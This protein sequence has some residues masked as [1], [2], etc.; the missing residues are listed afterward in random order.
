MNFLTALLAT[1]KVAAGIAIAVLA[2]GAAVG[3]FASQDKLPGQP[4]NILSFTSSESATPGSR[5]EATD[6]PAATSTPRAVVGIPT[7]NPAHDMAETPGACDHGDTAV[8]TTPSGVPVNVPCEAIHGTK[9]PEAD[10]TPGPD[11][12][13]TETA[14][15]TEA[16]EATHQP[17]ATE[18]PDAHA[19]PE[20]HGTPGA[21]GEKDAHKG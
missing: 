19:T 4:H 12:R 21:H 9:T 7:T 13:K 16:A 18:Q 14:K 8:K 20:A 17:E 5:I 10:E 1:H 6:T 15:P 2:S 11:E 3:T